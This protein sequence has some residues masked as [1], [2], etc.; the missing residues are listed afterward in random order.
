M[1]DGTTRTTL[2]ADRNAVATAADLSLDQ[3]DYISDLIAELREIAHG[4]KI[5]T[6]AALLALAQAEA[7]L[8]AAR[9]RPTRA[10]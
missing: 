9:R 3:L 6:L 1:T 2:T 4:A 8:E 5:E 7:A 10:E